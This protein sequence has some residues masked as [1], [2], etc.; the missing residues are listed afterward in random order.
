MN[1][2]EAEKTT[3]Y[4][5]NKNIAPFYDK[6]KK[7]DVI[8]H[9]YE[10]DLEVTR[11]KNTW[12]LLNEYLFPEYYE[13]LREKRKK[14]IYKKRRERIQKEMEEEENRL[15]EQFMHIKEM[16][17]AVSMEDDSSDDNVTTTSSQNDVPDIENQHP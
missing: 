2:I 1:L 7:Y 9:F 12:E 15:N 11:K 16:E 4:N 17:Y 10:M 6:V 14:E 8:R 3:G 13:E 5:P